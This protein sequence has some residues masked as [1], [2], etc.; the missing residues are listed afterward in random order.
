MHRAAV[1]EFNLKF[2]S[3]TSYRDKVRMRRDRKFEIEDEGGCFAL[4]CQTQIEFKLFR[5]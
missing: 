3:V 1:R 2:V 5:I 4:G